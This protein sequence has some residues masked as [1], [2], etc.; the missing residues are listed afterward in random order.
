MVFNTSTSYFHKTS[1]HY[2]KD[3]LMRKL[4][5][6]YTLGIGDQRDASIVDGP[7][8]QK[9]WWWPFLLLFLNIFLIKNALRELPL[10]GEPCLALSG[11]NI[12][13]DKYIILKMF[14]TSYFKSYTSSQCV[15]IVDRLAYSFVLCY[16]SSNINGNCAFRCFIMCIV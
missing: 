8:F 5:Y 6:V 11:K 12:M 3:Y 7:M 1:F 4:K 16:G 10:R 13:E 9:N 2:F 14:L 15:Q